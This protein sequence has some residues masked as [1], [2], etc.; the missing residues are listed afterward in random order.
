MQ[1]SVENHWATKRG[2]TSSGIL[3]SIEYPGYA[4]KRSVATVGA[5]GED[6]P[7]KIKGVRVRIARKSVAVIAEV[8]IGMR[9]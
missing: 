7:V 6:V 1:G 3:T 5:L 4:P 2:T 8:S 9:N